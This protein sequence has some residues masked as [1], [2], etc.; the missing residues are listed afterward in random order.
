M[1]VIIKAVK[2]RQDCIDYLAK[3]LPNA[4][5][6]MDQ[7]QDAM[8]TLL[9]SL[10]MAG[11]DPCIHMEEDIILTED[12]L[13]KA[14]KVI[15]SKPF[16]FIQFFSM[17]KKDIE[18]GSRW[19]RNFLMNQCFYAPPRYSNQIKKFAEKWIEAKS[20]DKGQ[21]TDTMICD[22]FKAK[23]EDYWIHCPSLVDHRIMKS[24]IDP[25]RSSKRQSFT[26]VDP[27]L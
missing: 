1:R 4:E 16:N 6:C 7:K 8:D 12:F 25:R 13:P 23:K 26:F 18:V 27:V 11:D 10:E 17:R 21:G 5:F 9:R 19:D 15:T 2:E 22:F 14:M 24:A 20:P 3:H